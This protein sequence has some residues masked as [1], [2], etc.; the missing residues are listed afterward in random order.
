MNKHLVYIAT[1]ANRI[2]IEAGYCQDIMLKFCELQT[3]EGIFMTGTPQFNRIVW[4][5]E[6]ATFEAAQKRKAEINYY[7]RMQKERLIRR[8]NP[9]W[10]SIIHMDKVAT[11]KAVVYA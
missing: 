3:A 7:T 6:F 8:S 4:I 5:E 11:K 9:N 2:F 1:D 10:L